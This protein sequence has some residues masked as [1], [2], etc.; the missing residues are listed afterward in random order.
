MVNIVVPA[1]LETI[2]LEGR[3]YWLNAD[4]SLG[5]GSN[6]WEG[7]MQVPLP[8]DPNRITSALLKHVALT[9]P[10]ILPP[11]RT[12]DGENRFVVREGRK[13]TLMIR[14]HELWR[15]PAAF[16]GT[17]QASSIDVLPDLNGLVIRFDKIQI[18]PQ[19]KKAAGNPLLDLRVVT[20]QGEA[21]LPNAVEVLPEIPPGR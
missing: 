6:I 13:A 3:Y 19:S 9:D 4:G 11:G 12:A 18:S 8:G 15:H 17:Q 1:W 2:R 14:G 16:L 21:V 10:F 20:M 7:E 5:K